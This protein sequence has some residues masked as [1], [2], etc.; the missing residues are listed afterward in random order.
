VNDPTTDDDGL[1]ADIAGVIGVDQP[2]LS[3]LREAVANAGRHLP[4]RRT[5]RDDAVAGLNGALTSVPDGMA[6]GLL[7]GVNPIY[8]LY[9]CIAGPIAGGALSS[10]QLMIV[11]T[12]SASALGAGQALLTIPETDRTDAL[13]LMVVLVGLLQVIFGLFRLGRLTRFVSY[14]VMTGFVAG[15]AINDR[16]PIAIGRAAVGPEPAASVRRH[17]H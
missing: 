13:F 15:I 1:V 11:A 8:G 14:S 9:A 2:G 10:T 3:D 17:P 16:G 6:S 7:A 4:E 12:T 5:V